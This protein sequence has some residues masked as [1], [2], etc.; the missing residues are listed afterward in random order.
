MKKRILVLS[1]VLLLTTGCTCQYNL[2]I[3]NN[4]YKEE[5]IIYGDNSEEISNFNMKW[6]VPIDKIE[7]NRGGDPSTELEVNGDTYNYDLSGNSLK[8][9]YDFT[10]TSIINSSAVSNCYNKLTI[11]NYNET[12][13]ISTSQNATC[14]DK[15]PTLSNLKVNIKVDKPVISNNADNV[16]GN[17]YTW[18]ITKDNAHDKSINMVLDNKKVNDNENPNE[19]NN[20]NQDNNSTNKKNKSEYTLYIFAGILL[21]VMLLAYVIF[22]KIK[23]RNNNMDD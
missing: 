16:N 15:Y 9:S 8:F 10:K 23:E 17:I 2:N 5:V 11:T 13:I 20:E 18:N 7:Y 4:I 19:N 21:I 22:N 6:K 1:I 3:E 14:Y 12:I